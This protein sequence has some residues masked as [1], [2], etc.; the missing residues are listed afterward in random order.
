MAGVHCSALGT[1]SGA[2][3]GPGSEPAAACDWAVVDAATAS[4]EPGR[5]SA[6]AAAVDKGVAVAVVGVTVAVDFEEGHNDGVVGA[7]VRCRCLGCRLRRVNSRRL[8]DVVGV[9]TASSLVDGG[10][11]RWGWRRIGCQVLGGCRR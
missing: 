10:P 3:T 1:A 7:E 2:V 11:L 8:R 9:C 6:A 4:K 5:R